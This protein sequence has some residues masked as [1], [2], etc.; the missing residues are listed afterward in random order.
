M[1]ADIFRSSIRRFSNFRLPFSLGN[2]HSFRV[3]YKILRSK[4]TYIDENMCGTAFNI[5]RCESTTTRYYMRPHLVLQSIPHSRTPLRAAVMRR[6]VLIG[7]SKFIG[8]YVAV[9]T[10]AKAIITLNLNVDTFSN[11]IGSDKPCHTP[12]STFQIFTD[13]ISLYRAKRGSLLWTHLR[14]A[15]GQNPN[16][17]RALR[18]STPEV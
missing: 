3:E 4:N 8:T 6:F 1:K 2:N 17:Q 16:R 7:L 5:P 14:D 12:K 10:H 9:R 13:A 18:Q 15:G 11:K